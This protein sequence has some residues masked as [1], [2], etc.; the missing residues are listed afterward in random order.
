MEEIVCKAKGLSMRLT[1]VIGSLGAGGAERVLSTLANFWAARGDQVS[2]VTLASVEEDF[3]ALDRRVERVGLNLTNDSTSSL[4]ALHANVQRIRSL[5]STI[6]DSHPEVVLSFVDRMNVLVLLATAGLGCPVVVSERADPRRHDPGRV[7]ALARRLVYRWASGLVVQNE[8]I[9]GWARSRVPLSRIH[10]V[11]N[12]IKLRTCGSAI[13]DRS[14]DPRIVAVGRLEHEKAFDVLLDAFAQVAAELPEWTMQLIGHGPERDALVDQA[15]RY[16]LTQRVTFSGRQRDPWAG[17]GPADLFVL[18]SRYEGEPNAL[19]E[20][21]A[22]GV[23]AIASDACGLL[24]HEV[25]GLVVP[26]DDPSALAAAILR[27]A[28]DRTLAARLAEN[29]RRSLEGRSLDEISKRW[30]AVFASI[31]VGLPPG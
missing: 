11:Q 22:G 2:L 27:L 3:F 14:S 1:L 26:V 10:I 20:A 31:G 13:P 9:A 23:P 4:D 19:L 15:A 24:E 30:D 7:W 17:I 25:T 29:A 16:G 21:M 12:P 18:P 28:H 6:A 5:R 8:A